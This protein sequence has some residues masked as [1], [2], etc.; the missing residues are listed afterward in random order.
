MVFIDEMQTSW[1][2]FPKNNT[3]H[4]KTP[5]VAMHSSIAQSPKATTLCLINFISKS[6]LVKSVMLSHAI[7]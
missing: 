4:G 3:T 5:P 6:L 2:N 1:G 7:I